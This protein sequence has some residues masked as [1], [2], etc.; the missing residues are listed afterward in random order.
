MGF[1]ARTRELPIACEELLLTA[2]KRKSREARA[3]YASLSRIAHQRVDCGEAYEYP[4]YPMH[5]LKVA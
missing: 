1:A 2:T 5:L 4:R 3:R